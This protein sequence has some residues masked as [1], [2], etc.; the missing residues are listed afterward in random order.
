MFWTEEMHLP[1]CEKTIYDCCTRMLKN[2]PVGQ[3]MGWSEI[4]SVCDYITKETFSTIKRM[5]PKDYD[6]QDTTAQ[7]IIISYLTLF[8]RVKMDAFKF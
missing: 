3:K 6:F 4:Q 7:G 2:H 5:H 1:V 8:I